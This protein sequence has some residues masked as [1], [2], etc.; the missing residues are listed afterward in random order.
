MVY[1]NGTTKELQ[2]HPTSPAFRWV[3]VET[4]LRA[5][6]EN[7]AWQLP[8]EPIYILCEIQNASA[9]HQ[10]AEVRPLGDACGYWVDYNLIHCIHTFAP[11]HNKIVKIHGDLPCLQ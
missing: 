8:N 6:V 2:R 9:E 7:P 4:E 5:W 1:K 3:L 11:V 10:R